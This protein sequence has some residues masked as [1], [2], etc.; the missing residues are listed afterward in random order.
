MNYQ[1]KLNTEEW[2]IKRREIIKRDGYLC[3]DCGCGMTHKIKL[4]DGTTILINVDSRLRIR[5]K[6]IYANSDYTLLGF[7]KKQGLKNIV[8]HRIEG[9]PGYVLTDKEG[10][11]A[12]SNIPK[13]MKFSNVQLRNYRI[14][15]LRNNYSDFYLIYDKKTCPELLLRK[16][17]FPYLNIEEFTKKRS[18]KIPKYTL[19]L[20]VHHKY[21]VLGNEPWEYNNEALVT[22]CN[23]CHEARHNNEDIPVYGIEC[24]GLQIYPD[25][26]VCYKCGGE[27]YFP[28]W[29]H[30]EDGICFNCWG[31]GYEDKYSRIPFLGFKRFLQQLDIQG[32]RTNGTCLPTSVLE[33]LDEIKVIRTDLDDGYGEKLFAHFR[34]SD[35]V[36]FILR[37]DEACDVKPKDI[38]DPDSVSVHLAERKFDGYCVYITAQA[39]P[40]EGNK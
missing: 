16:K 22:L 20:Q 40:K 25:Y 38:I 37:I 26:H 33:N 14:V 12:I 3:Q 7:I 29:E 24:G 19:S 28:E 18:N 13:T 27:G 23:E 31:S 30:I 36:N 32:A 1:A 9:Y 4:A 35:F 17:R 5:E 2:H 8:E 39:Y 15:R 21:Y 6:D 11:I 10:I 34:Y